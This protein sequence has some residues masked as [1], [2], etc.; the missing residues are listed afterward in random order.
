MQIT[1]IRINEIDG[2][3]VKAM[4]N[5][6]I[7]G[8]FVV[9]GLRI[10]EGNN[11]PFVSMPSRKTKNDEYKDIAFPITKEVR[12]QIQDAVLGEWQ[13][14]ADSSGDYEQMSDDDLPF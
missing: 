5:I 11:G 13:G 12:Q 1:E 8:E 10:I 6:T 7:D 4:A 9:T 14:S 2:G 3:K